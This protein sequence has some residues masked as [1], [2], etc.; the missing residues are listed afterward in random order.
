VLYHILFW[1]ASEETV[2]KEVRE[3]YSGEV[4]LGNDL[5]VF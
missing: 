5:D 2:L 4:V 3:K 1:G